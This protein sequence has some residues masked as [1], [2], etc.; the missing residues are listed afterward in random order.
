MPTATISSPRSLPPSNP[1][2]RAARL[3]SLG[4]AGRLAAYRDGDLDAADVATWYARYPDEL[5]IVNG[6][7][8]W[9][10]YT[11]E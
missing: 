4:Q 7:F 1:S 2:P 5:P 6:E 8:E 11:L 9:I 3:D 10:A